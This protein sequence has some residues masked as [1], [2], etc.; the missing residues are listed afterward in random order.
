LGGTGSYSELLY[1][2]AAYTVP[3][4][5]ITVVVSF[6]PYVALCLAI[7]LSL[8]SLALFVT[9]INAT[10]QFGWGKAL[11]SGIVL[12]VIILSALACFIIVILSLLGPQIGDVFSEIIRA[13]ETPVSTGA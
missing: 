4:S 1:G 6:I 9:A 5:M 10:N 2:M 13:L 11:V 12:P 8:Y 7:P 3:L